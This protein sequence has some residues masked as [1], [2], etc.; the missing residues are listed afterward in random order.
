MIFQGKKVFFE[1]E[2]FCGN[3]FPAFGN[4]CLRQWSRMVRQGKNVFL[5]SAA[6]SHINQATTFGGGN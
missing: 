3:S 4:P 6:S 1:D 2:N 5:L